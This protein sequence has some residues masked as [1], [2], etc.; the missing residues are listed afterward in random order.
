MTIVETV[1]AWEK[2]KEACKP[3][4]IEKVAQEKAEELW[5]KGWREEQSRIFLAEIDE[6]FQEWGWK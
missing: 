1:I 4:N 5:P 2:A 3:E 6:L